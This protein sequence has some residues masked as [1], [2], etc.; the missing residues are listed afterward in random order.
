MEAK[1]YLQ[2]KFL[3]SKL[4]FIVAS[5]DRKWCQEMFAKEADPGAQD[6]RQRQANEHLR[7]DKAGQ[8]VTKLGEAGLLCLHLGRSGAG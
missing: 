5:D 3:H 1:A 7:V 4:V 8:R 2:R 6:V